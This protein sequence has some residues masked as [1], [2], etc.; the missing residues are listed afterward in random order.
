MVFKERPEDTKKLDEI[1]KQLEEAIVAKEEAEAK[2]ALLEGRTAAT[3]QHS[4]KLDQNIIAN[5]NKALQ[6]GTAPPPPPLPGTGCPPP[7]PMPGM[8]GPLPPP[9]PGMAGPPPPPMPGIGG[10][11]PPPMPGMG[12]PP[13]P[14]MPGMGVPPPPPFMGGG[15]PPPPFPGAVPMFGASQPDVL[16]FGLKP[17][18]K[19]DVNGPLKKA[20]WKTVRKIFYYTNYYFMI[21]STSSNSNFL[22]L[23]R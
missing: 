6:G 3:S 16:P 14:P 18:K 22:F 15:A 13:P 8:G 10:P 11:P 5:V 21:K 20:N 19:W 2:V 1:K 9:M 7:P 12:G 4:G 23:Y 17:K